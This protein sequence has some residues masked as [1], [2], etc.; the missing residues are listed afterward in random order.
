MINVWEIMNKIKTWFLEFF[1]IQN[2]EE[3]CVGMV[4][5]SAFLYFLVF[6]N[7]FLSA[8][9]CSLVV[10]ACG[11]LWERSG[12][13]GEKKFWRRY[14]CPLVFMVPVMINHPSWWLVGSYFALMGSISCGY[15][16]PTTQPE[17]PGSAIGRFW[18]TGFAETMHPDVPETTLQRYSTMFTR[19]TIACLMGLSLAPLMFVDTGQWLMSTALLVVGI[20]VVV[21]RV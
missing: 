6:E 11:Y 14:I 9:I 21:D 12:R 7:V 8:T 2:K 13:S 19:G 15:G 20:V 17:D 3:F 1:R 16:I 5:P 10:I 18:Y 4:L